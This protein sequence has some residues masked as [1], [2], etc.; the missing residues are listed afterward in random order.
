MTYLRSF[1]LNFL[2]VFFLAR[3]L[4]GIN[5]EYFE[6]VPNVGLDILFAGVVGFLNA[7]IFYF[8]LVLDVKI[9]KLKLAISAIIISFL[10]F[11]VIGV[12]NIGM[13]ADFSGVMLGGIFT[14]IVSYFTNYLEMKHKYKP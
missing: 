8:W 9:T 12:F 1:F 3:V 4:P 5:I 7:S 11:I 14:S 2:I 13:Q 6:N 10:S